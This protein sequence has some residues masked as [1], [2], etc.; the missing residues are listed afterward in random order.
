MALDNIDSR[1]FLWAALITVLAL[2]ALWW[3]NRD[4]GA[5]G[6]KVA[7]AGV[8]VAA[9]AETT[10]V[11]V[12]AE[13]IVPTTVGRSNLPPADT[14]SSSAPV[15]LDGPQ[16]NVGGASE[17]AVPARPATEI[18]LADATYRSTIAGTRTCFAIGIP[19]GTEITVINVENKH[20]TTCVV[21]FAPATQRDA[22]VMQTEQFLELADLSD[23][24][25]PVEIHQ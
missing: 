9:A 2:P 12:T 7:T 10:P 21:T 24:P 3:V 17:I 20:A 13:I 1:R 15:F 18:L 16:G 11:P 4:D 5:A 14:A 22:L 19:S 23:A 6:P 25:I 8:E